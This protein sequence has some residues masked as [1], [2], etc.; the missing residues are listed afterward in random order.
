MVRQSLDRPLD[1]ERAILDIAEK[2]DFAAPARL[3]D[4]YGVL[5]LRDIKSY[6]DFAMP[7]QGPPS[8][9]E[10]R[11]GSPEQ[12]SSYLHERAG[13]RLTPRT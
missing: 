8:V 2:P 5:L 12:P 6:K 9:H 11:L 13:R 3:R 1:R 10:A 4:G 7:S